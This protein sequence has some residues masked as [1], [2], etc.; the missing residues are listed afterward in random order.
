MILIDDLYRFEEQGVHSVSE[1]STTSGDYVLMQWTGLK[2]KNGKE[3]YEGDILDHPSLGCDHNEKRV[4]VWE[5]Y[6]LQLNRGDYI[7]QGWIFE[8]IGNVWEQLDLL[9]EGI[10]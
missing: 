3:V 6:G 1:A 9:K 4:V 2:D 8:V 10:S 7:G 5:N